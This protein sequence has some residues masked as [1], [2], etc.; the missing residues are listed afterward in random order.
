MDFCFLPS[1]SSRSILIAMAWKLSSMGTAGAGGGSS[2]LCKAQLISSVLSSSCSRHVST[3][4]TGRGGETGLMAGERKEAERREEEGKLWSYRPIIDDLPDFFHL[5]LVRRQH[6]HPPPLLEQGDRQGLG[7]G[8]ASDHE[9]LVAIGEVHSMRVCL[10]L[11]LRLVPRRPPGLPGPSER[12]LA[13]D[14]TGDLIDDDDGDDDSLKLPPPSIELGRHL[15]CEAEREACLRDERH[16][17]GTDYSHD[18]GKAD[19]VHEGL[20][21]EAC[22]DERE[23]GEEDVRSRDLKRVAE[24]MVEAAEVD[25]HETAHDAHE[26][27]L[28]MQLLVLGQLLGDGLCE[29]AA[30][31][32]DEEAEGEDE[33]PDE[34][35]AED[36]QEHEH[37]SDDDPDK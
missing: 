33:S 32:E 27:G 2:P 36:H 37:V 4:T 10:F 22:S 13:E 11:V 18:D 23:E 35:T 17:D 14:G 31:E 15:S 24:A 1:S 29:D 19:G 5:L 21:V 28:E 34:E 16:P 26:E 9:R 6:N 20:E 12:E 7:H 8:G 25:A 3:V 30:A